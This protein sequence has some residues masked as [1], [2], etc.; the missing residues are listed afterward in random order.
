MKLVV[1]FACACGPA[2]TPSIRPP[3]ANHA[4]VSATGA[5]I[6]PEALCGR[7]NTLKVH[8]CGPFSDLELDS[9][10]KDVRDGLDDP[11]NRP[12]VEALNECTLEIS[13]CGD[14]IACLGGLKSTAK[15]RACHEKSDELL[16]AAV[17][18]PHD[19][20]KRAI[21]RGVTKFSQVKSSKT[22]P[23]EM[24]GIPTENAWLS[25]L[26]C[27][28]GTTPI[29]DAGAETSRVGNLG[30]G[31]RCNSI[32]DLYRVKCP[33]ASYDIYLDGYVCPQP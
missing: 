11:S 20:W 29:G 25:A 16:G 15:L 18:V 12:A 28:D 22:A 17:G 5:P 24:C 6:T 14:V 7:L 10:T 13:A 26:T 19:A 33:E 8:G 21:K 32:I 23:I 2:T 31:G 4:T 3:P 1:V 30:D 9:C 27:D